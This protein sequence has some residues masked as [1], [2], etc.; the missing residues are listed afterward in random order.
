MSGSYRKGS[1]PFLEITE[2]QTLTD[3]T[4]PTWTSQLTDSAS[5]RG[6]SRGA[7][8]TTAGAVCVHCCLLPKCPLGEVQ[9]GL[10]LKRDCD[11]SGPEENAG[12][13][14]EGDS[15]GVLRAEHT[16]MFSVSMSS[17]ALVVLRSLIRQRKSVRDKFISMVQRASK[18]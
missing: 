7:L 13:P 5:S 15:N 17:P 8:F 10:V 6:D 12:D 11:S 4:S 16:S 9:P 14:I 3:C 1:A 18:R 2:S